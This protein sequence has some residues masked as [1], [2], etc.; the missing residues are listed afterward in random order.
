MTNTDYELKIINNLAK[1]FMKEDT[2]DDDL[3]IVVEYVD[4]H[5]YLICDKMLISYFLDSFNKIKHD[6]EVKYCIYAMLLV[7]LRNYFLNNYSSG[8]YNE[9]DTYNMLLMLKVSADVLYE[10]RNNN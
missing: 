5:M 3:N 7:L 6:K 4:S 2:T 8:I 9:I 1:L 10:K